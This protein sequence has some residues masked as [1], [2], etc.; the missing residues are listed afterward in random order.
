VFRKYVVLLSA[1][2]PCILTGIRD[3]IQSIK[4]NIEENICTKDKVTLN[5]LIKCP[6]APMFDAL[7]FYFTLYLSG[8]QFEMLSTGALLNY[9]NFPLV[10]GEQYARRMC[11]EGAV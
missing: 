2:K 11:L 6:F 5:K 10:Y 4:T 1:W 3:F 8:A 9:Y 7:R